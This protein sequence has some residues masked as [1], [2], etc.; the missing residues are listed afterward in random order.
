MALLEIEEHMKRQYGERAQ[1]WSSFLR[2]C[3]ENQ[4]L[5]IPPMVEPLESRAMQEFNLKLKTKL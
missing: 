1:C 3:I 5:F 4:T 2:L